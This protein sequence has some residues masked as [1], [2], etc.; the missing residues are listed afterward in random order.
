MVQGARRGSIVPLVFRGKQFILGHV[1]VEGPGPAARFDLVETV[2]QL[3][4]ARNQAKRRASVA[5]RL[6]VRRLAL[7]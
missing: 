7:L 2:P 5:E 3:L 4:A 1:V 6:P